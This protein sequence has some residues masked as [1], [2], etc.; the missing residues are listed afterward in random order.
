MDEPTGLSV[1][2][3]F[4]LPDDWKFTA[5]GVSRALY[6]IELEPGLL[7]RGQGFFVRNHEAI[8]WIA[9]G[10]LLVLTIYLAANSIMMRENYFALFLVVAHFVYIYVCVVD[11]ISLAPVVWIKVYLL[12]L[13]FALLGWT[14]HGFRLVGRTAG[15][16]HVVFIPGAL[17]L[18]M[19]LIQPDLDGTLWW[20]NF[21]AV[22]LLIS[23]PLYLYG[24]WSLVK[25]KMA[26]LNVKVFMTSLW[27]VMA[28]AAMSDIVV[29]H[30]VGAIKHT[31]S[32]RCL[33]VFESPVMFIPMAIQVFKPEIELKTRRNELDLLV[34]QRT[35]ELMVAESTL[36]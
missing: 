4:S 20:R 32:F 10:A 19:M 14:E 17:S 8:H 11:H 36:Q 2:A 28:S 26:P 35:G 5:S 29:I 16:M 33:S 34:E 21:T 9:T 31:A 1:S 6:V 7:T 15:R 27:V 30:Q 18:C 3:E 13:V 24:W 22:V 23:S 12:F 25:R